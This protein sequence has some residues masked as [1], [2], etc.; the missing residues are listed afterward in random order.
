MGAAILAAVQVLTVPVKVLERSKRRLGPLL[1]PAERAVLSLAMFED[2]LDAC[3][4]QL[5]WEV[6]VLSVSE[7]ALEVAARRGARP[8]T[9]DGQSLLQAVRQAEA[10]VTGRRD[11]MAVVLGD[12]PL[13]TAEALA[14]AVAT[15][16]TVVAS[17]AASD[18]GTNMLLRRPASI[19]PARFGRASFAKHRWA[20]RRAG[21]GFAVVDLPELAFDLDRPADVARFLA[22]GRRGRTRSACLEMGLAGRLRARA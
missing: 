6:W 12:L 17:P 16:G 15:P 13:L 4:A 1:S 20:A 10:Q 11:S 2:V 18:G 14:R 21:V 8:V 5:D 9:E 3:L 19:I 7:A 22:A